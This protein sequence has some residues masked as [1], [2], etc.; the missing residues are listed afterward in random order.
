[1]SGRLG[2][3]RLPEQS[4][5]LLSVRK[6]PGGFAR[7]PGRSLQPLLE[8]YAILSSI[9]LGR[10]ECPPGLSCP[11]WRVRVL[12]GWLAVVN[13]GYSKAQEKPAKWRNKFRGAE[14]WA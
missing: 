14:D 8:R 5:A 7:F 2:L 3:S 9:A 11:A 13:P 12:P 4:V 10:H 1:M 6:L